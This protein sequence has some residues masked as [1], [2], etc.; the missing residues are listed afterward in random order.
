VYDTKHYKVMELTPFDHHDEE[1]QQQQQN[2]P[3]TNAGDQIN[4]NTT[5]I[6]L[7]G[8]GDGV[9][10]EERSSNTYHDSITALTAF[11]LSSSDHSNPRT[12]TSRCYCRRRRC[13]THYYREGVSFPHFP[14]YT[15][16]YL[17]SIISNISIRISIILFLSSGGEYGDG[18]S[19]LQQ[20]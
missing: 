20:Q 13:R 10:G 7:H 19:Q 4:S 16:A 14:K 12:H 8:I 5:A 6:A 17:L 3:T 11:S 9:G 1:Q 18:A 2:T 15:D